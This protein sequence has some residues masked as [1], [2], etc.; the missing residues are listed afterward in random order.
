[1]SSLNNSDSQC[2]YVKFLQRLVLAACY[3]PGQNLCWDIWLWG[4]VNAYYCRL[5]GSDASWEHNNE[6]PPQVCLWNWL[7]YIHSCRGANIYNLGIATMILT[8]ELCC[9]HFGEN[10]T[11]LLINVCGSDHQFLVL[12]IICSGNFN[13]PPPQSW[14]K[15]DIPSDPLWRG[16]CG[17]HGWMD[18]IPVQTMCNSWHLFAYTRARRLQLKEPI[19]VVGH[20]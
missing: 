9:Y 1:M 5:K 18:M 16:V 4:K 11:L 7:L 13:T 14:S 19:V 17:L 10:S 15:W 12:H 3:G 20:V 8:C 6:P 2:P